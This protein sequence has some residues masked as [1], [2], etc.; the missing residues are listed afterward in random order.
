MTLNSSSPSSPS[1]PP[2]NPSSGNAVFNDFFPTH[3]GSAASPEPPVP[4]SRG[5]SPTRHRRR[6]YHTPK[7]NPAPDETFFFF[8]EA[9]CAPAVYKCQIMSGKR[10]FPACCETPACSRA[11]LG[12]L[13]RGRR[14]NAKP[15][16]GDRDRRRWGTLRDAGG[17]GVVE[18]GGGPP[19][20]LRL[21]G[22]A[23]KMMLSASK[24][25]RCLP[26]LV[27]FNYIAKFHV[28]QKNT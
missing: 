24:K 25:R 18:T 23:P 15:A 11:K 22:R 19:R 12:F 26:E 4:N 17:G 20:M 6:R 16:E 9:P 1:S 21:W 8:L 3:K 28:N 2:P 5:G 13:G 14:G 10:Q 27:L 7:K